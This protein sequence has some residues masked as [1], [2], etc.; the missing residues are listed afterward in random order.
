[1]LLFK[2]FYALSNLFFNF[3]NKL[4]T[5]FKIINHKKCIKSKKNRVMN[6]KMLRIENNKLEKIIT[7][8]TQ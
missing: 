1:M 2:R 4:K 8:I 7:I 6:D 3:E 5:L